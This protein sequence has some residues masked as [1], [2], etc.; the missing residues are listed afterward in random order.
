[1]EVLLK[2]QMVSAMLRLRRLSLAFPPDL[3]IRMGEFFLLKAIASDEQCPDGHVH[4]AETHCHL[5]ITRPAVSQML[6]AL[7]NKNYI[8]REIDRNDRRK[9]AV[10]LTPE[11]ARVLTL[12]KKHMDQIMDRTISRFGEEN[13]QQLISLLYQLADISEQIGKE[14]SP[15]NEKGDQQ[16][17]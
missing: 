14:T 6:N 13:T 8:Q 1:M 10:R 15:E 17:D 9:I 5:H 12:A 3:D 4:L 7:E 16:L 11:G 2:E